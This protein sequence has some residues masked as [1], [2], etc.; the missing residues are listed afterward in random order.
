MVD[1][2]LLKNLVPLINLSDDNLKRLA[3]NLTIE[4]LPQGTVLCREGDSDDDAIYLLEGGVEMISHFSTL[5]RVV[6][7]GTEEASY[8]LAPGHPRQFTVTA[9]TKV[10]VIR[11]SN[12]KLNRIVILDELTTTITKISGSEDTKFEGNTEWL[13][14]MLRTEVFSKLPTEKIGPLMFKM[15]PVPVKSGDIVFKQ[16]DPG[17]YYYIIK[18]GRFNVS[19]K[20]EKGKVKILAELHEGSVFGEESLISGGSRNAS[21]VAMGNGTLIRLPKE[22]FRALLRKSLLKFVTYEEARKMAKA[23][24]GLLDVRPTHEHKSGA[25]RGSVNVPVDELRSKL[26][27]LDRRRRY[28]V[29]CKSGVQSEV[30]AFLLSQRGF[31][32]Y[33]LQGGL[34]SVP[35]RN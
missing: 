15:K 14:Q 31:D 12:R 13:E 23:G 7:G 5:T 6:Q 1:L 34:K 2:S 22:D 32:V 20:D 10:R 24:A 3:K 30:A 11:I 4:E 29:C 35:K 16:G 9:T 18:K 17:D 28:I 33:V 21:I 19:R 8:A 25:L 26:D 27:K